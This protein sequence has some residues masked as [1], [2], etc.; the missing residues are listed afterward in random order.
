MSDASLAVG[1]AAAPLDEA[2]RKPDDEATI[3][4][5]VTLSEKVPRLDI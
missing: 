3:A 1:R 2:G 5:T 4:T